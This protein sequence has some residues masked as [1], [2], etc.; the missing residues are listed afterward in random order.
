M[1]CMAMVATIFTNCDSEND[2]PN[3]PGTGGLEAGDLPGVISSDISLKAGETYN[4]TGKLEVKKGAKLTIPAGVTIKAKKGFNSYILVEQGGKIFIN[5]TASQPVKMTAD[6]DNAKSGHWGGLVING[7]AP[8]TGG[9]TNNT[10]IDPSKPYGGDNPSDNSGVINYLIL[11]YTGAQNNDNVEHNGLTLNAVGN[12]TKIENIYVPYGADD[13]VEFFGGS[14]NVTNILSVNADDDMFDFTEGYSG[15]LKNAYGVWEDGHLSTEKDPR[16]V[17]ADGNHDG[18]SPNDKPQSNFKIMDMTIDLKMKPSTN[19]G[20]YMHDVM[21]IRRGA[22]AEITNVLVK[23]QGQ[24]KDFIDMTDGKG[25]G[26]DSSIIEYTNKLTTPLTGKLINGT[27][28]VTG[29]D[30]LTGADASKFSWTNYKF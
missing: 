27:A 30:G 4:L 6:I 14:V 25:D 9:K 20:L 29:K 8:I 12:G 11:E 1:L 21:K 24:A 22:R 10:E 2:D 7:F 13:A 5:G 28:K 17:E 19:D 23:G 15:T 26:D 16:G 18:L 3:I